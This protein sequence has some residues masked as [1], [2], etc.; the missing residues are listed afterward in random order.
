MTTAALGPTA[1]QPEHDNR[2]PCA[3]AASLNSCCSRPIS[4]GAAAAALTSCCSCP[5]SGCTANSGPLSSTSSLYMLHAQRRDAQAAGRLGLRGAPQCKRP[6]ASSQLPPLRGALLTCW[7]PLHQRMGAG[8]AQ[9]RP[10]W[11]R[12]PRHHR[13]AGAAQC[14]PADAVGGRGQGGLPLGAGRM[15]C[16]ALSSAGG[17]E[18]RP[19]E[20]PASSWP[21]PRWGAVQAANP[22]PPKQVPWLHAGALSPEP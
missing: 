18:A 13:C 17:G 19:R 12:G 11:W 10:C 2:S 4:P 7:L 20:P 6:C 16:Y 9:Q 8:W 15:A 14:V 21:G 5:I 22:Q 3:T 1:Q